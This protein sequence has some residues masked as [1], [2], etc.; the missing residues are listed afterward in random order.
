[1]CTAVT[2]SLITHK[3]THPSFIHGVLH[4]P[5]KSRNSSKLAATTRHNT[6]QQPQKRTFFFKK[7]ADNL[8]VETTNS[9][10]GKERR[11][12]KLVDDGSFRALF[13]IACNNL[14]NIKKILTPFEIAVIGMGIFST[15]TVV[16]RYL[17]IV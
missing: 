15:V 5:L 8:P 3:F 16:Y 11:K 4:S 2:S 9:Q 14:R 6:I 7:K 10:W 13:L 1:M 12:P 17:K